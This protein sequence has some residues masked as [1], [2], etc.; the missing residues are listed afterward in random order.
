M[1]IW[2]TELRLRCAFFAQRCRRA[3]Q[4]SAAASEGQRSLRALG[5]LPTLGD[6]CMYC[7]PAVAAMYMVR[8]GRAG[9]LLAGCGGCWF[10]A[11]LLDIRGERVH[12]AHA[13][14][15]RP[16]LIGVPVAFGVW[17]L[18][19]PLLRRAVQYIVVHG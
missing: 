8:R 11:G 4:G 5:T 6:Y 19:A 10:S 9:T 13:R 14:S 17:H 7:V 12:C 18:M 2:V 15:I 1:Y 3:G 16:P